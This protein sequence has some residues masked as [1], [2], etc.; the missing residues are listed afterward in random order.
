MRDEKAEDGLLGGDIVFTPVRS[1][2]EVGR[3]GA[4]QGGRA[5][6]NLIL[7]LVDGRR[8]VA[9]IVRASPFSRQETVQYLRTLCDEG[10]LL[11]GTQPVADAPGQRVVV[12]DTRP[13][14][15]TGN[16]GTVP[17][18]SSA[19]AVRPNVVVIDTRARDSLA[20]D[21]SPRIA[22]APAVPPV[23]TTGP[24]AAVS[25]LAFDF[26]TPTQSGVSG[27]NL[28][29]LGGYEVVTRLG[30][31]GMGSVYVCRKA[32][33]KG[34]SRLYTLKVVRQYTA[35]QALAVASLQREARVGAW[36]RHPSIH[37][38]VDTATYKGQ[39]YIILDYVE[40]VSLAE[41]LAGERRPPAGIVASIVL[42]VLRA[43]EQTHGARDG[44]G[45]L[46]GLVHCDVSPPNIL[47]G[48]D[49]VSRLT[50]FGSC[51]IISEEGPQR[52]DA[53]KLGKPSYMAPE[54]L[55][56][57]ALDSRTDLFALGAVAYAALTGYDLFAADNYAQIVLNVMRKRIPPPS[58]LGAPSSLDDFCRRA[59][60]R[61][62]DG[63]FASASEM[64]QALVAASASEGLLASPGEVAAYVRREFGE[65][66]DEQRRRIQRVVEGGGSPRVSSWDLDVADPSASEPGRKKQGGTLFIPG[67]DDAEP[68]GAP[69]VDRAA[70]R[71]RASQARRLTGSSS[72]GNRDRTP[73]MGLGN[74]GRLIAQER[75]VLA[76][77]I[78]V[79]CV[80]VAVIS[81]LGM[82]SAARQKTNLRAPPTTAGVAA[83][84]RPPAPSPP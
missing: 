34:D 57:E 69:A 15:S 80:L 55:R 22:R 45:V 44:K 17:A 51:Q 9:E 83:A 59:L 28:Y 13:R 4:A 46:R 31:G 12:I 27:S 64:A 5:R 18:A 41:L 54:Q 40:G 10:E 73:S 62:R 84:G 72:V 77:S 49:G 37:S 7:M 8:T 42:D 74:L 3:A 71:A 30:Q 36:L 56:A 39:P 66:L 14:N 6:Q 70:A 53:L 38:V 79:G 50:D 2:S 16:V 1:P 26:P 68:D 67:P 25:N 61:P 47:V 33:A 23:A 82:S 63:R 81:L 21:S 58:E 24:S 35:Q 20:S 43:L 32:G 11:Q 19:G 75:R 65:I 76:L 78:L 48:A 60:S 29:R 52:T